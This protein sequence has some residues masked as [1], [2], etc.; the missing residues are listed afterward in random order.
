MG[1]QAGPKQLIANAIRAEEVGF[2][3]IAA[4]DHHSP[5]LEEQ[6][7][8]PYVWSVLGALAYATDRIDPMTYMTCPTMRYHL[9]AVGTVQVL[10]LGYGRLS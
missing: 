1:E 8:S 10:T 4:S 2:D 7:H 6:G 3:F 5:W 9:A